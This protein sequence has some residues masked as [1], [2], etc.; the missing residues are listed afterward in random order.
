M[1]EHS[2]EPWIAIPNSRGWLVKS[3]KPRYPIEELGHQFASHEIHEAQRI[4]ACI[5]ACAGIPTEELEHFMKLAHQR[6]D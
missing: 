4:V 2:P 5:N 1:T 6:I 3:E